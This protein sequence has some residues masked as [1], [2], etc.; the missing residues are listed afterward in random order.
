MTS[1]E[2]ARAR[3]IAHRGASH[4]APEN[5]LAAF[6]AAIEAEAEGIELDVQTSRDGVPMV[7]HDPSLERTT[8]GHGPVGQASAAEMA[9]LEAG[10]WFQPPMPGEH[11]PTL[12][13]VLALLEPTPLELHIELKTARVAYPGLV[14]AVL[15]AVEAAGMS[16][17]VV[18]SSF[19]HHSLLEVRRLAP[20]VACAPLLYE[21]FIEPWRYAVQHGFRAL[22]AQHATID[23]E[24]VRASHEAGVAVRAY[25]VDE[26]EEAQR[27]LALGVDGL[28]TNEPA[29]LLRLRAQLEA[30]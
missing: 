12:A 11:V 5:T 16:E 13:A 17:R 25:T 22:H 1:T 8:N 15:Q 27:L 10:T 9:A 14:P 29:R 26:P 28:I 20:R 4:E 6:R 19:N 18:L 2:S 24:L 23:A 30:G 7:I 3:I 21:V